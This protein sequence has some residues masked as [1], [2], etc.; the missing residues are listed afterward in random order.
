[1]HF[2]FFQAEDG[3]RDYKVTGFRR[4]LFRSL[5]V[6]AIVVDVVVVADVERGIGEGQVDRP[7]REA[8]QALDAVPEDE[9]ISGR[10]VLWDHRRQIGRASCRERVYIAGCVV[11]RK[12]K[13][14][15]Q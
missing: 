14:W 5:G 13:K 15:M 10:A 7:G 1:F 11:C 3:I 6:A 9:V 12:K 2:F 4:V 8:S